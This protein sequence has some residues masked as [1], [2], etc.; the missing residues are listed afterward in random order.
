MSFQFTPA[1]K[2]GSKLRLAIDGPSGSGKTFTALKVATDLGKRVALIDTEHKSAS[3]YADE[4]RFDTL[5][6]STFHP[7]TYIEAIAAAVAAGYDVLV[8]DSLSHAWIGTDGALEMVD[9]ATSSGSGNSFAAWKGVTPKWNGLMNAL[10][11]ADVHLI[12]TL[13]SKT[14][15]VIEQDA[16]GKNVPKKI[17][18]APQIRD[19]ADYEFDVYGSMSLDHVMT[20]TKSR[21]RALDGA[22]IEKPGAELAATLRDWLSG[23]AP[24]INEEIEEK[25]L[26]Y[27]GDAWEAKRAELSLAVSKGATS[28]PGNLTDEEAGKII[29]GLDTKLAVK[30]HPVTTEQSPPSVEAGESRPRTADATREAIIADALA[31]ADS[32]PVESNAADH[33]RLAAACGNLGLGN[34]ARSKIIAHLFGVESATELMRQQ[35]DAVVRWVDSQKNEAKEF[36]PNLDSVEEARRIIAAH[37]AEATAAALGDGVD[38]DGMPLGSVADVAAGVK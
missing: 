1:T 18:M 38:H 12:A 17:G 9:K 29:A 27:Y 6:L 16:R 10:V 5:Q 34:D 8:I 7:D 32:R 2:A 22:V 24:P 36:V 21:C 35:I 31:L 11:R 26:A 15:Y 28:T 13:R 25:G 4:F 37:D 19:G 14:D 23:D 20:I 33:K 3:K 30:N